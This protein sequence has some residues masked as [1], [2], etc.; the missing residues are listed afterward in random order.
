MAVRINQLT[1]F[2]GKA[3]VVTDEINSLISSINFSDHKLVFLASG[4]TLSGDNM[5]AKSIDLSGLVTIA[6]NT[7]TKAGVADTAILTVTSNALDAT[8]LKTILGSPTSNTIVMTDASGNM[9]Y[10]NTKVTTIGA[11]ST[12]TD[13]SIPTE[14]AVA[15]AIE[16]ITNSA[17]GVAGV[18]GI[19]VTDGGNNVKNISN[20][21]RLVKQELPTSGFAASYQFCYNS[22]TIETPVWSVLNSSDTID[23]FKDQFLKDVEIGFGTWTD[24]TTAPVNWS[25]TYATGLN[26]VMKMTFNISDITS[27]GSASDTD[28]VKYIKIDDL[29]HDYTAG[30]YVDATSLASNQIKV[31]VGNGIDGIITS[32][33]TVKIDSASGKVYTTKG[34]QADVI[35]VG[36]SGVKIDNIQ[37]AIDLAVNDEHT[38]AST[39]ISAVN[40]EVEDFESSVNIALGTTVTNVDTQLGTTVSNV[41]TAVTN[42]VSTVSATAN[43]LNG[44]GTNLAT[45]V[46]NAISATVDNIDTQLGTTVTN[47]NTQVSSFKASVDTTIASV[48]TQGGA[49]TSSVNTAIGTT[50]TNTQTSVDG[51]V[52][53][54]NVALSSAVGDINTK[55]GNFESTVSATIAGVEADVTSTVVAINSSVSVAIGAVNSNV[56]A[57]LQNVV[58]VIESSVT[59][60][61]G[62]SGT[63]YTTT[64]TAKHVI[65]V[66]GADDLQIYPEIT[67]N[68]GD[69]YTISADY[70]SVQQSI[71]DWV[72]VCT[73]AVT[74][75][76]NAT[77]TA[78]SYID[79]NSNTVAYAD[80]TS[81]SVADAQDI[82]AGTASYT[83]ATNSVAYVD[84]TKATKATAGTASYTTATNSIAYVD[85]SKATKATAG[86]AAYDNSTTVA[87]LDYKN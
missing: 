5:M 66:Y 45:S 70:G 25:A 2:K 49:L 13:N 33:I 8:G 16:A 3:Y 41:N 36:A 79:N 27:S 82:V 51:V 10:S 64:V 63:V 12:A 4:A 28:L 72:V 20:T 52:S 58:Q 62:G 17:I 87:V 81:V 76:T 39:A 74:A 7:I 43:N 67:K 15:T 53:N 61:N 57:S 77:V 54:V 35:S 21:F 56:S 59:P 23:L 6:N 75:Y 60:S 44:A 86:T 68:T 29:F 30:N 19:T 48:N 34:T 50:V 78:M 55:V 11:A 73:T 47:V 18:N 24:T 71:E 85:A 9:D 69:T 40:T 46:N 38:K 37:T 31:L 80:V 32:A 83:T 42:A 84:A 22:G 26:C 1:N 14:K 65:A